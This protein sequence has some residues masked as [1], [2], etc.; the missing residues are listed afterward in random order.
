MGTPCLDG[1]DEYDRNYMTTKE[2]IEWYDDCP[3]SELEPNRMFEHNY[4]EAE[5]LELERPQSKR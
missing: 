2:I 3:I 1:D 5:E 4:E